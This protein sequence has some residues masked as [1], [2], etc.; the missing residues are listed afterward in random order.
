MQKA[1]ANKKNSNPGMASE[2]LPS[3][4]H[5][6]PPINP[7]ASITSKSSK[8]K[9]QKHRSSGNFSTEEA[10]PGTKWLIWYVTNN[11]NKD[12]IIFT[13]MEDKKLEHD[14]TAFK[15]LKDKQITEY[16]SS[17]SFYIANPH[18]AAGETFQVEVWQSLKDP[19]GN[20]VS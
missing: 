6:A 12:Q 3:V 2:I 16:K 11:D 14:P 19:N 7:I 13:V 10:P 17:R 9:G 20:P 5:Q 18:N 4:P 1:P 15:H 8:Q